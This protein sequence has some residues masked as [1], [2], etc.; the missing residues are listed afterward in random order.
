[1]YLAEDR[2]RPHPLQS[3]SLI[4]H[5]LARFCA[6]SSYQ[7]EGP[8]GH[9]TTSSPRMVLRTLLIRFG[10]LNLEPT[11]KFNLPSQIP[12]LVSQRRRWLNGSF[13]AAIHSTVHFHYLYRSSHSFIRKFWIHVE[14]IYQVFNLIFS[15]FALVRNTPANFL[16]P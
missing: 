6:G 11:V 16:W 5:R 1:M 7:N 15:W 2:V 12:E 10:I 4:S 13:F 8:L 3:S 9:Y 14:L